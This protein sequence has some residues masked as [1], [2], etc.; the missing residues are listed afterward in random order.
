MYSIGAS[1]VVGTVRGHGH[2]E[3]EIIVL[4]GG[5]WR[6]FCTSGNPCTSGVSFFFCVLLGFILAVCTS[7]GSSTPIFEIVDTP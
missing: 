1:V 6:F 2:F 5:F 3:N 7:G 4:L